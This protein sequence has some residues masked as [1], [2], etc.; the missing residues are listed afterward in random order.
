MTMISDEM[1]MAYVDGQLAEDDRKRVETYLAADPEAR[2]RLQVFVDTGPAL[3][4]ALDAAT[5]RPIPS[6]L[7]EAVLGSGGAAANAIGSSRSATGRSIKMSPVGGFAAGGLRAV[8][9][10]GFSDLWP[11]AAGA[12]A[13]MLVG[14]GIGWN[15]HMTGAPASPRQ[16]IVAGADGQL[17]AGA[18]L[19]N[20]LETAASGTAIMLAGLQG[21]TLA[22]PVLSFESR[23]TGV[24]RQ[25]RLSMSA[26]VGSGVGSGAS[27]GAANGTGYEGIACRMASGAWRIDVHT[28]AAVHRAS[29]DRIAPASGQGDSLVDAVVDR[30]IAGDAFSRDEESQRLRKSWKNQPSPDKVSPDRAEVPPATGQ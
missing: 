3:A 18:A 11:M 2:E 24:C 9:G 17:Q 20:V 28:L 19:Q 1:L 13:A 25:Y 6:R 22:T 15:L 12:C 26:T 5:A 16:L 4:R 30:L 27:P 29:P 23:D 21:E 10:R 8:I 14:A 7:I